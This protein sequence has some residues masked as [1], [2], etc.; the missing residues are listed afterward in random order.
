MAGFTGTIVLLNLDQSALLDALDKKLTEILVKGT[1]EWVRTVAA[2]IPN[3]SGQSRA[4][5]KPI[6]D[7]VG[8]PIFTSVVD[9]APDRR[10]EGEAKGFGKLIS[11]SGVYTFAWRSDVFYLAINEVVNVNLISNR[12]HL[13]NPGPYKSQQQA[14]QSFFKTVNPLLKGLDYGFSQHVHVIR[15]SLNG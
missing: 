13:R 1:T 8:V 7:L 6:A 5:L 2:I 9:G 10:A 3:W 11:E 12:F 15:K 4:S 14:Q